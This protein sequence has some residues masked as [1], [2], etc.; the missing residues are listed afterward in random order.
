MTTIWIVSGVVVSRIFEKCFGNIG[1]PLG[2][3]AGFSTAF[4]LTWLVLVSK[5]LLLKPFPE[6]RRGKCRTFRG[7]IWK[8]GTIYGRE[9]GGEF[10][11]RCRC[12]D[13]YVRS[14]CRFLLVLKDGTLL[15]YKR[16]ESGKTWVDE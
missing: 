3:L 11:Y 15:P 5:Y 12:G 2:F 9:K 16:H 4:L 10:R 6:C 13:E 1:Y 14:G 7:Y 8:R